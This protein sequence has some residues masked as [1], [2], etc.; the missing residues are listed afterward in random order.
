MPDPLIHDLCFQRIFGSDFIGFFGD[1]RCDNRPRN[2]SGG[3]YARRFPQ[4]GQ[5]ATIQLSGMVFTG[6][7][8]F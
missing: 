3:R 5:S 1:S 6:A 4:R 7:G 8:M 2:I